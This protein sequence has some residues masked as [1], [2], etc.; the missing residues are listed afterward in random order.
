MSKRLK[1]KLTLSHVNNIAIVILFTL[2]IDRKVMI[3]HANFQKR[4]LLICF[5]LNAA[6]EGANLVEW[7]G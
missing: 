1:T 5:L 2:R 7:I 6:D 4:R 3:V